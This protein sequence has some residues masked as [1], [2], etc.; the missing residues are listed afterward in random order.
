MKLIRQNVFHIFTV[1][2]FSGL[3]FHSRESTDTLGWGLL[4]LLIMLNAIFFI[5]KK[6][7]SMISW[8]TIVVGIL[9]MIMCLPEL[10]SGTIDYLKGT[11]DTKLRDAWTYHPAW[12]FTTTIFFSFFQI[13]KLIR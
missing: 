13:V 3:L 6:P 12:Y 10:L 2:T 11:S 7:I 9:G 5:L 8:I 4:F 1:I